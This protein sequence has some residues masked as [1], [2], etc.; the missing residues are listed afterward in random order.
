MEFILISTAIEVKVTEINPFL[1]GVSLF[2]TL[3][4]GTWRHESVGVSSG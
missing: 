2:G 4:G 3:E 1:F